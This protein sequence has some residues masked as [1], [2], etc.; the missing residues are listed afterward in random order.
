MAGKFGESVTN[1]KR[2]LARREAEADSDPTKT[3]KVR[4]A[5]SPIKFTGGTKDKAKDAAGLKAALKKRGY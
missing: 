2:T 1:P 3:V 4:E 5:A